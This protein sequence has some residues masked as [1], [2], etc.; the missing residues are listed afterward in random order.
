MQRQGRERLAI[1]CQVPPGIKRV[2][3]LQQGR[4]LGP[5]RGGRGIKERQAGRIADAPIGQVEHQTGQIGRQD[6][7]GVEG[8]QSSG[9]A[10]VPQANADAG[11]GAAGATTALIGAGAGNA[12]GVEGGQPCAG[13]IDGH[14]AKT[15][16]DDDAHAINGQ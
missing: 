4:R 1:G 16:I 10:L 15:G 2:E 11:G 7:G 5:G 3:A 9:L 14:A 13:F 8:C 12:A 6:F